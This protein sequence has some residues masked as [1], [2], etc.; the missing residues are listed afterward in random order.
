MEPIAYDGLS[1]ID[2]VR[3]RGAC[4]SR[5]GRTSLVRGWRWPR[6]RVLATPCDP[7]A[8]FEE[9]K[10]RPPM[11][12]VSAVRRMLSDAG[13]EF[14]EGEPGVRLRKAWMKPSPPKSDRWS[15]TTITAHL[16]LTALMLA[17][18][19]FLVLA[20]RYLWRHQP[21]SAFTITLC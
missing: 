8:K 4:Y 5:F 14:V 3:A 16:E 21:S 1:G 18:M 6:S 20:E 17:G 13:V 2:R 15:R 11:L 9:G 19:L 10:Q 12:D 7:I